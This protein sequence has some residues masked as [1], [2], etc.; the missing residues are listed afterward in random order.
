MNS[1]ALKIAKE[2]RLLKLWRWHSAGCLA[3]NSAYAE[4]SCNCGWLKVQRYLR[5]LSKRR[6]K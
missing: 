1:P 4:N 3:L 2:L 6:A 5:S